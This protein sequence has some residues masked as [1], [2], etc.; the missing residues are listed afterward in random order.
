MFNLFSFTD[1]RAELF[2]ALATAQA[3]MGSAKKDSKNPHFR[4]KYA[5]LSA[6]LEAIVPAL[7]KHGL[8][9]L[10]LPHFDSELV[11]V[12]TVITHSSGQMLSS[13]VAC[14]PGKKGDAQAVGS[15]ITYLRRYAAQSI[16]GLPVDDDD[17]N[18]ASRHQPQ[19]RPVS[20]IR[21]EADAWARK[22]KQALLDA[23]VT[24]EQYSVWA[25]R[26]DRPQLP[27]LTP[28]QAK[29]ALQWIQHGNGAD[30]IRQTASNPVGS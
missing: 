27:D 18:A 22:V 29:N 3:D 4:S 17:G 7:N 19:R 16:L 28:E 2:K 20:N 11:Q 15:A 5:S 13:T 23:G 9:L 8:A 6:V 12:T 25:R 21:P 26:R 30:V 10:Q 1:D 24:V 14:P